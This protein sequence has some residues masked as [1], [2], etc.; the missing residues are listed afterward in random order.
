MLVI[1]NFS[2]SHC[3][4]YPVGDLSAIFIKF[5]IVV[6]KLLNL[7]DRKGLSH[8]ECAVWKMPSIWIMGKHE[9]CRLV[10]SYGHKLQM[11]QWIYMRK[12]LKV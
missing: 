2:F 5:D 1:S 7:L 6:H 12:T 8:F 4:F 11:L 10:K 3:V 9:C